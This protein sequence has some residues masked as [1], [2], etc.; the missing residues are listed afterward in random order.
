MSLIVARLLP[1]RQSAPISFPQRTARGRDTAIVVGNCQAGALGIML[2]AHDDFRRRFDLV[3]FPAVHELAQEDIPPLHEAV[4]RAKVAIL[5]RVDESY[6]GLGVGTDTLARLADGATVIRWPSV[7]WS[8]Y[9]P[10]LFY[11]RDSS[12]SPVVDGQFDYHDRVILES[13]AAGMSPIEVCTRLADADVLSHAERTVELATK[14]LASRSRG[15]DVQ[16]H[17][18][19]AE[20]FRQRL[21][22]FTM[23]HPTNALIAFLAQQIITLIGLARSASPSLVSDEILGPTFYPLHA[24]HVRTLKLKFGHEVS[25]GNIAFKIRGVEHAPAEAVRAFF[26]YYRAHPELVEANLS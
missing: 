23:N 8:G 22:F 16:M 3:E 19:I 10:D 12:G 18:F 24:N 4:S 9:F 7:F 6:R 2:R 11:M 14:E 13:Y 17:D 25:A 21:L 26:D 20:H 1:R 5:Q 15:C